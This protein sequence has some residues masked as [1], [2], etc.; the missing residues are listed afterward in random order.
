M[1]VPYIG[2]LSKRFNRTCNSLGI[3]L[4]F[5]GSSTIHIL[6]VTPKDKDTICQKCGVIYQL[7][8]PQVY[9]SE[10]YTGESG[11]TFGERFREHLRAPFPIYHH[12]QTTGHP[13]DVDCFTIVDK[14]AHGITRTIKKVMFIFVYDPSLTRNLEKYQ[15]PH[16]WD[17]VL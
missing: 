2:R 15:L 5:N 12:S 14:V 13:V 16:I 8:C 6:L 7:K 9:C 10:K 1:V 3:Q 4:H 11:R 17:E